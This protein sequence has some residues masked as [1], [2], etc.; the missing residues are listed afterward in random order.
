ML[1]FPSQGA[2]K[3]KKSPE[4]VGVTRCWCHT[5]TPISPST[6]KENRNYC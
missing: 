2:R 6:S 3:Y 4:A 1:Q 5:E